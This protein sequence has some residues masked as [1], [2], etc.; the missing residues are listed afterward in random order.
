VNKRMYKQ[1][2][3]QTH[4]DNPTAYA[5]GVSLGGRSIKINNAL[6]Q[7]TKARLELT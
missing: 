3:S 1:A 4:V 7:Y 5:C 6:S 2:D